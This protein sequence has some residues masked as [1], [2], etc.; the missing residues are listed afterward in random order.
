MCFTTH[1]AQMVGNFYNKPY[2]FS[3]FF[4]NEFRKQISARGT[5]RFLM[6]PRFVMMIINARL[7]N[8]PIVE[9]VRR[10]TTLIKRSYNE[11]MTRNTNDPNAQ[12]VELF[13]A[14]VDINYP[15]PSDEAIASFEDLPVAQQ[16]HQ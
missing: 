16:Q 12:D 4:F 6:Y 13:E 14:I 8:F 5:T 9:L 1:Q 3:K 10:V 15:T 2:S 7:P 11:F